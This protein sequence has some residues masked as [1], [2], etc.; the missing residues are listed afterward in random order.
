M[1]TYEAPTK[2]Q[3]LFYVTLAHKDIAYPLLCFNGY[4]MREISLKVGVGA[5]RRVS[6]LK[7][8]VSGTVYRS[9]DRYWA[10]WD[11][12]GGPVVRTPCSQCRGPGFDP[13]SGN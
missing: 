9:N 12:P 6:G 3:A 13:W 1:S 10:P 4:L 2:G 5:E 8:V 7:L 11:F